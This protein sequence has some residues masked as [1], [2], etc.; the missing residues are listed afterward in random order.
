MP[1][2]PKESRAA[3]AMRVYETQR[4][5]KYIQIYEWVHAMIRK[6]RFKLGDRLP[7]EPDL[8]KKFNSSRMTVRKAIDPL[9]LEGVVERRQ[10]QGTFVVSNDIVKL[11]FDASKPIR[12]SHEMKRTGRDHLFEVVDAQVI[13]A[14]K[15]LQ[16]Y[17]N[18]E[19]DR[20]VV[21]LTQLISVDDKPVIIDRTYLPYSFYKDILQMD[22]TVPP[23][24]LMADEFGTE[25]KKVRQYISAVCAGE[26]EMQLFKVNQPIPCIYLEWISCDENGLPLSV[27]LCYYRGD[28][29][30]FKIPASELVKPDTV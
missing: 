23:M 19:E 25:V 5:P 11:T 15:R 30:K 13:E 16:K 22:L 7:T 1:R 26:E 28:A 20:R 21:L 12:F 17:I 3:Y 24:Q 2:T 6:G 10:G 14:D 27:S 4:T 29:F 9:V 8:A 18:L